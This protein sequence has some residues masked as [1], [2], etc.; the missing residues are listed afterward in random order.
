MSAGAREHLTSTDP[1]FKTHQTIMNRKSEDEK[2]EIESILTDIKSSLTA[3]DGSPTF[4]NSLLDT[5]PEP[6]VSENQQTVW[7]IRY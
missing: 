2:M 6:G 7:E 5:D 4:S 1:F 3:A